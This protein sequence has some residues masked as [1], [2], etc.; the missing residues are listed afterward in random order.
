MSKTS[1]CKYVDKSTGLNCETDPY[2][3][4]GFCTVHQHMAPPFDEQCTA[5]A[6]ND[7]RVR[8]ENARVHGTAFCTTH[9]AV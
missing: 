5:A 3:Y 8:C 6:G 2:A 4:T 1:P 7:E 9:A